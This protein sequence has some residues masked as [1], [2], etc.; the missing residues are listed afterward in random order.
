[1]WPIY[2]KKLDNDV[3]SELIVGAI[4]IINDNPGL[5]INFGCKVP[6]DYLTHF[7]S[8]DNMH[9]CSQFPRDLCY[10]FISHKLFKCP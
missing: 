9:N 8:N 7:L 4:K 2:L 1:M 5:N 3:N 10:Q 6:F